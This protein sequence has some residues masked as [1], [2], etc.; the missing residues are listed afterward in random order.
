ML[1]DLDDIQR[2]GFNW[3]RVWATWKA[4]DQDVSAV[5]SEGRAR[6]KFMR[7]LKW[8]M[9]QCDRRGTIVDVTIARSAGESGSGIASV[10][11]HLRCLETLVIGLKHFRNWYLDLANDRN[12]REAR[13]VS[14]DELRVLRDRCRE[15]DESLMITASDVGDIGKEELEKQ[16]AP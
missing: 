2:H 13:F 15:L 10:A 4:F 6:P 7:R 9:E 5:D 12:I 1:A 16:S 8:L 14:L 3:I 11:A